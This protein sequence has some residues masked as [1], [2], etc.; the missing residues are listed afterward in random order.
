MARKSQTL[1]PDTV[2]KN[3]WRD[4]DRFADLFNAALFQGQQIIKPEELEDMDS[5]ES[6]ILEHKDYAES[7]EASRD[8]I[9]IRKRSSENG[10]EFV[11][12]GKESQKHI[13]YAMPLRVMGYDYGTYKKQYDDNAAKYTSSQGMDS[14][15]YLSRMKQTDR[16]S[17]VVTIVVYYSEKPWDGAVTLHEMLRI[18]KEFAAYVND[19]KMILVEAGRNDLILHNVDNVDFFKLMEIILD[20]QLPRNEARKKAIQYSEEHRTNKSVVMAI[21]GAT[22]T[23]IDYNAFQ[24]GDGQM[25]T[26]FDT[27]AKE[28]ESKGKAEGKA[29]E[30]IE[31]GYEFGMSENDILERLQTKL[32]VSLQKAQ[33]YFN[34]F[35][36][37]TV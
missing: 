22:D 28:H 29:E 15:E 34:M 5:E 37:Q 19:Y 14:D 35:T 32:D 33:E 16:F 31:T 11:M 24:K 26:L 7:I 13:H 3:Y 6:S 9:K 1:K 8:N 17:P 30:I 23:K 36:K 21:A 4:N 27:I 25:C 10:I 20:Q 2:L 12:L 18:P